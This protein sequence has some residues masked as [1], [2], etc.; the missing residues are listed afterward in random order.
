MVPE[1]I[2]DPTG[3]DLVW[4]TYLY[5]Q[6]ASRAEGNSPEET[7][8]ALAAA[9]RVVDM[10]LARHT[11][12]SMGGD[13]RRICR[14]AIQPTRLT[15]STREELV[16]CIDPIQTLGFK[17]LKHFLVEVVQLEP[18]KK[19]CWQALLNQLTFG[20]REQTFLVGGVTAIIGGEFAYMLAS[21]EPI[22][23]HNKGRRE[24]NHRHI[25]RYTRP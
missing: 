16:R 12:A 22:I 21:K 6:A 7:V 3:V 25:Y 23:R 5:F 10:I 15:P 18:W 8:D 17:T 9:Q 4:E 13:E 1:E 11:P 14:R 20:A 24:Q 2:I 19:V